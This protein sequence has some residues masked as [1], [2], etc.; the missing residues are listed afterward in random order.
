MIGIYKKKLGKQKLF[1]LLDSEIWSLC[2]RAVVDPNYQI[3]RYG[4]EAIGFLWAIS[5][6]NKSKN[7]TSI[8]ELGSTFFAAQDKMKLVQKEAKRLGLQKSE[9]DVDCKWVGID[10]SRFA[11]KSSTSFAQRSGKF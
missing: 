5:S 10:N 2:D 6:S 3:N 7:N 11:K 9:F 1:E 8:S 4:F